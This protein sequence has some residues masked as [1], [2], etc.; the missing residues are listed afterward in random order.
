MDTDMEQNTLPFGNLASVP[1]HHANEPAH[2]HFFEDLQEANS[3]FPSQQKHRRTTPSPRSP[4]DIPLPPSPSPDQQVK[5]LP[6]VAQLPAEAREIQE[7]TLAFM[8]TS[9]NDSQATTETAPDI[10]EN[11]SPHSH[12]MA[13]S[14]W[15]LS[16]M[17]SLF[18]MLHNLFPE[19]WTTLYEEALHEYMEDTPCSILGAL[20][21]VTTWHQ[22][23]ED[24]LEEIC[25]EDQ[26]AEGRLQTSNP[27]V[28]ASFH[29]T[30]PSLRLCNVFDRYVQTFDLAFQP[31]ADLVAAWRQA[32]SIAWRDVPAC[33]QFKHFS[34]DHTPSITC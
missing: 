22:L 1:V 27:R 31:A 7:V 25:T 21:L 30:C 3:K 18:L 2:N 23:H 33:P 11:L 20:E 10:S 28:L 9:C 5:T 29:R 14:V 26:P 6:P 19:P 8:Q 34:M 32:H 12:D 4:P 24:L 13:S 15:D 17:D 16:S